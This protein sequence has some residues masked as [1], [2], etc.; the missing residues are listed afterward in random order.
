MAA[1]RPT[2]IVCDVGALAPDALAVEALARLHLNA[3]R[4]GLELHLAGVSNEL[5]ALLALCG[6][7]DVLNLDPPPRDE[8]V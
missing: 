3:K 8:K 2:P 7:L 5:Q 1:P 6:L 4:A